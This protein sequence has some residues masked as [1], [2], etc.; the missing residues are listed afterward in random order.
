M[1][2]GLVGRTALVTG[3]SRGIGLAIARALGSEGCALI[4]VARAPAGL[5]AARAE[6]VA[7]GIRVAIDAQDVTAAGAADALAARH[8]DV[9]VLV[10]NAGDI[11]P[12]GLDDV[13]GARWRR[14]WEAKVFGYIDLT[15]AFLAGMRARRRGV[16]VNVIGVAGERPDATMLARGAGSAALMAVTRALGATAVE[17]GVRVVGVNPGPVATERTVAMLRERA[18]ARLGDEQRWSDLAR[19]MP[20]GRLARPEEIADTVAFLASERSA[21]TSGAIVTVDGGATHRGAL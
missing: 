6:L 14:G 9:D 4:L 5:E 13:D 3:A 10:N 2:L 7:G 8:S 21:Y 11:P 16:I 20:F 15:R 19:T 1:D 17:A 12:G 18:R